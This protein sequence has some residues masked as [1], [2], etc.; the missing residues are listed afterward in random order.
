MKKR[1]LAAIL[2]AGIV[3][4]GASFAAADE[5]AL[6]L[7][8]RASVEISEDSGYLTGLT[9]PVNADFVLSQ[10]DFD[11]TITSVAGKELTGTA[12]VGSDSVITA[13]DG[14][15]F[16][17]VLLSGDVSRDGKINLTDV[18][19]LMKKI[20]RWEMDICEAAADVNG[21]GKMNLADTSLIMQFSA[22][23]DVELG[24]AAVISVFKKGVTEYSLLAGDYSS[25][26]AELIASTTGNA[27]QI[28]DSDVPGKTIVI[29]KNLH[30]TYD[31][32]DG[33][34][35]AALSDTEAYIDTYGGN[36]Y[37]T[38][39]S[40][41]GMK[42]CL[43]YIGFA[44]FTPE[45]DMNIAKGKV[46]ALGNLETLVRPLFN[47]LEI[48]GLKN[49]YRF[50]HVTDSHITTIYDDEENEQRRADV[51]SR[52]ND[53]IKNMYRMPSYLFLN[54]YFGYAEDIDA[55]AI[56]LTGDI[57][58]SPSRSNLDILGDLVK[59]TSVSSYFVYGN[60]DWTWNDNY[61]NPTHR[62]DYEKRFKEA[63]GAYDEDW[64][65]IANCIEYDDLM[66]ISIDNSGY[67]FARNRNEY[68]IIMGKLNG[69]KE[70]GKPVLLMLH[71]PLHTDDMHPT[72]E[73]NWPGGGS[74]CCGKGGTCGYDNNYTQMIYDA[75]VA[76]D[77][78]VAAIFAGHVHFNFETMVA[79][80][81]PQYVTGAALEGWCRVIDIVP[82]EK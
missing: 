41:N 22:M 10:L 59:N 34:A 35:V 25:A 73:E 2:A 1:I 63:V 29:G 15:V 27:V 12:A 45:L 16:G 72:V 54:E 33:E 47:T 36:I 65:D 82:T 69:A 60:H 26:A 81:I 68:N 56:L 58:D 52:L 30:E 21:D 23:W 44:G 38:A 76:E 48:P 14:T 17:R 5:G 51:A 75:I 46:S 67:T 4:G 32:I 8:P 37:L 57:T 61:Q 49:S 3:C 80:R 6:A 62:T 66:I 71:I 7:S 53:W 11:A 19:N 20:A 13:E 31:F 43:N 64:D 39:N 28:T 18:S 74:L 50:L 70:A 78:P 55:D 40:D 77:S 24:R 79:G 42:G 9:G